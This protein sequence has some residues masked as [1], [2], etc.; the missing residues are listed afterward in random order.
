MFK[1]NKKTFGT[2][3]LATMEKRKLTASNIRTPDP[4]L[5]NLDRGKTSLSS[6]VYASFCRPCH[7]SD[8]R[9]D[10]VRFPP[11]AQSEWVT[12]D[13]AR[14]IDVILNGLQG[15]IMVK[16]LSYSE[17][18]PAHNFLKDE[19]VAEVLTYIRSSFGNQADAVTPAEVSAVRKK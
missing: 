19:E 6:P 11:L 17:A 4:I 8:G 18:M 3:Q 13:K 12:G 15:P 7:Q 1:G 10:G 2:V 5:D 14:L 16:G 9:G